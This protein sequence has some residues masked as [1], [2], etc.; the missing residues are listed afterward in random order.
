MEESVKNEALFLP[1][2]QI[3]TGHHHVADALMYELRKDMRCDKVDILSYSY[4]RMEKV[5]SSTYLR[6]IKIMPGV[7]DWLY[8]HLAYKKLS[9]RNRQ[10]LYETLFMYFFKRLVNEHEPGIMFCTHALPSNIA[11]VLKQKKKLNAITINV[12]TDFFVNRVWGVDG[13]DY[14][15]V[16]SIHVKE[17]LQSI[18]VEEKRIFITG[19]P[20]HPAFES[21]SGGQKE[22]N[23]I[24]VLVTGGSLGV[25]EI[26]KLLPAQPSSSKLHYYVLCGENKLLYNQLNAKRSRSITPIPY[27]KSKEKMNL[28]YERVDAVLTKPGG[29]TVSECL[30]KRKPIFVSK[31]LPGQEKINLNQLKALGVVIPLEARDDSVENQIVTFF[32]DISIQKAYEGK[33]S[34]YHKNLEKN[35]IH[36]IMDQILKKH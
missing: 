3:P 8:D 30:I 15:F 18:G 14:H 4:G 2:M 36:T 11:S 9:K 16:P 34:T 26:D 25:G 23:E 20:V 1:F 12:Y 31:A 5:V 17:F 27:V 33:I 32:T 24:A 6:W 28:L 13:I 19:I 22:G 7:Y 10:I 29:V 21:K 35:S